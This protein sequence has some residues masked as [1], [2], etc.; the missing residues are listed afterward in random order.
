M[1]GTNIAYATN[2]VTV[3][4]IS[5]S[6]PL[7]EIYSETVWRFKNGKVFTNWVLAFRAPGQSGYDSQ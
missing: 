5:T 6:P 4:A 7:K 3:R 1:I 2:R